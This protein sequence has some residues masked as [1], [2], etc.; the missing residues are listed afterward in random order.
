MNSESGQ[1]K[2]TE[3]ETPDSSRG[4][5]VRVDVDEAREGKDLVGKLESQACFRRRLGGGRRSCSSRGQS[6]FGKN[7][8][9]EGSCRLFRPSW[10]VPGVEKGLV[11]LMPRVGEGENKINQQ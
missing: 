5:G 8:M 3:M 9:K 1:E 7:S 10:S 6:S 2:A 4:G 11:K